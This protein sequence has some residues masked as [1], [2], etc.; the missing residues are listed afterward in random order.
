MNLGPIQTLYHIT[1]QAETSSFLVV[2]HTDLITPFSSLQKYNYFKVR[3]TSGVEKEASVDPLY[4][5]KELLE[6]IRN[7]LTCQNLLHA[8]ER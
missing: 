8:Q 4:A 2:K 3:A 7:V 5:V 6:T 1:S